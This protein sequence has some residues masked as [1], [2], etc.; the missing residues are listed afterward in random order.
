[1]LPDNFRFK[2]RRGLVAQVISHPV[3]DKQVMIV[4]NYPT[5][6]LNPKISSP[7]K[8]PFYGEMM[9]ARWG[10]EALAVEQFISNKYNQPFYDIN[11]AM[12]IAE[13]K[14][15]YWIKNL[16]NK[17]DYIERDVQRKGEHDKTQACTENW[18]KHWSVTE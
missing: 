13:Y 3:K 9:T 15:N 2:H 4:V 16:E 6:Q 12:S 1:M 17:V 5:P 11:K 14:K 18:C 8:I 7:S 10:Y